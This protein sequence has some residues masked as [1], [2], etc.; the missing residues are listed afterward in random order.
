[1]TRRNLSPFFTPAFSAGVPAITS[2]TSIG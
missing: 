2:I 1:L